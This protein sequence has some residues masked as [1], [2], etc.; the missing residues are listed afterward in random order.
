VSEWDAQLTV[1]RFKRTTNER[2]RASTP[3]TTMKPS[4]ARQS[5]MRQKELEGLFEQDREDAAQLSADQPVFRLPT[6]GKP[7]LHAIGRSLYG[8]AARM[9]NSEC[10]ILSPRMT[11]ACVDSSLPGRCTPPS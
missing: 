3:C 4:C 9:P 10:I 6:S 2:W 11:L 8:A 1:A 7:S 5:S